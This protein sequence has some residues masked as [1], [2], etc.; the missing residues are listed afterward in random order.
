MYGIW[1]VI[2]FCAHFVYQFKP[3]YDTWKSFKRI[4]KNIMYAEIFR[5]QI[6]GGHTGQDKRKY[7][8]CDIQFTTFPGSG[9]IPDSN[10]YEGDNISA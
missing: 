6:R 5:E 4:R 9:H 3:D 1:I 8:Q 2:F 10:S 7:H